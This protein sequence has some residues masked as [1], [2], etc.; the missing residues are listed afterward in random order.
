MN[1]KERQLAL[2]TALHSA[3]ADMVVVEPL[4]SAMDGCSTKAL[5]QRLVSVAADP[6]VRVDACECVEEGGG[7][8]VERHVKRRG[9][10]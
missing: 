10:V 4:R 9:G 1:K 6:M 7:V 8:A 2:A 5:V 3:T